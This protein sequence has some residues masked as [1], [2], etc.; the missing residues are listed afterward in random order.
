VA[1]LREL[2]QRVSQLAAEVPE[3]LEM[4]LN[5]VIALPSGL[6]YAAVDARVKVGRA[7]AGIS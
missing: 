7:P 5:P 2:L 6:G 1:A 4:D 3:I